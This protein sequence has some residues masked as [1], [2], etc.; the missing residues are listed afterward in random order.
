MTFYTCIEG[1]SFAGWLINERASVPKLDTIVIVHE[2]SIYSV[3][4]DLEPF[5]KGMYRML[6]PFCL[7]AHL[8]MFYQL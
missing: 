8:P 4:K 2:A 3:T 6:E 1:C 5:V 7:S